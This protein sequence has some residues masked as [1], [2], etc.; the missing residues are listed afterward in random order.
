MTQK[1]RQRRFKFV[2]FFDIFD[3]QEWFEKDAIT[4]KDI[5]AYVDEMAFSYTNKINSYD[6][7]KEFFIF[8]MKLLKSYNKMNKGWR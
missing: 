6:D 7:C 2:F 5:K 1:T 8:V 4:Q 3:M